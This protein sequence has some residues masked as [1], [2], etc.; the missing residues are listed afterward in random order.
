[1]LNHHS[2]CTIHISIKNQTESFQHVL[3]YIKKNKSWKQKKSWTYRQRIS[4]DTLRLE[5][6]AYNG[7][8]LVWFWK[9]EAVASSFF[10]F[11]LANVCDAQYD[12]CYCRDLKFRL[13][14]YCRN[15]TC[16]IVQRCS[17]SHTLIFEKLKSFS[18]SMMPNVY[19][20]KLNKIRK[21]HTIEYITWKPPNQRWVKEQ[22][23]LY[24]ENGKDT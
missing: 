6:F 24:E 13:L 22:L 23:Q 7:C 9:K 19:K 1:M 8:C 5:S 12:E 2:L 15:C 20:R 18:H 10:S 21:K 4:E 17:Q 16:V 3:W 14:D 11:Q